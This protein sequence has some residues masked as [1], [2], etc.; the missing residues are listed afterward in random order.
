M[1]KVKD[2]HKVGI[3]A[4]PRGQQTGY[5]G[6]PDQNR[7]EK[8]ATPAIRGRRRVANKQAGDTSE[9]NIGSDATSPSTN[10][11]STPA[12]QTKSHGGAGGAEVFKKRLARKRASR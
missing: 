11:P 12:M 2:Q 4:K 3:P 9:Q 7:K 8:S 1:P 6:Q 10:T 5:A